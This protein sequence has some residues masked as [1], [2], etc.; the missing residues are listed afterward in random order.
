[1][2]GFGSIFR[3]NS[4]LTNAGEGLTRVWSCIRRTALHGSNMHQSA[5]RRSILLVPMRHYDKQQHRPTS[6]RGRTAFSIG[7]HSLYG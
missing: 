7:L 6:G 1:M 4:T 3:S 2:N 5:C